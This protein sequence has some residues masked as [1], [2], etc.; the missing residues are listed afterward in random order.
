LVPV[1]RAKVHKNPRSAATG[2]AGEDPG[3]TKGVLY[4]FNEGEKKAWKAADKRA[5]APVWF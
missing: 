3:I 5:R 4:S 2:V 1:P